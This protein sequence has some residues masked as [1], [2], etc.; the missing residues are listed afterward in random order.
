MIFKRKKKEKIN[1]VKTLLWNNKK[2][3]A[4]CQFLSHAPIP[5]FNPPPS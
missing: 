3:I 2:K 1:R 4:P 5:P